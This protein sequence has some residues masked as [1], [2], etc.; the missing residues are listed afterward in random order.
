M[1]HRLGAYAPRLRRRAAHPAPCYNFG[2]TDLSLTPMLIFMIAL[3]GLAAGLLGGMLGVGGSVLMIPGLTMLMG[4]HQH[5]YQAAAMIA[6]VAVAVPATLRHVQ[7]RAVV[8]AVLRWMIPLAVVGVFLGVFASNLPLFAD[9]TGGIWLGRLL[10]IFLIYVIVVNIMRLN[11]K[12]SNNEG[13]IL[14]I[15]PVRSGSI[16]VIMGGLAGLLGIGGGAVAVP[17]QQVILNLPLRAAIANSSA[18]M[19]VSATFGAIYKNATLHEHNFTLVNPVTGIVTSHP[20][21]WTTGLALA[22][23]LAPTC[24]IGGYLGA[25][26]THRLPVRLMRLFFIA[27]MILAAWKMAAF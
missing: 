23:V 5:L 4:R 14:Y 13:R 18:V 2:M 25:L 1:L 17:L 11:R 20:Y 9:R 6:N 27:L 15:T 12:Q 26:L 16:G 8:P 3:L 22:A 10:A 24:W 21:S 19:V 7:Y